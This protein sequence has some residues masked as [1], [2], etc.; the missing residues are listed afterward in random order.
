MD[1]TMEDK[2]NGRNKNNE[3]KTMEETSFTQE[4]SPKSCGSFFYFQS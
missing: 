4:Q 1:K 2:N 3:I